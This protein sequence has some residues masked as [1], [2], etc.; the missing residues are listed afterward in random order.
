MFDIIV[1]LKYGKGQRKWY[2]KVKLN[3]Y[4]PHAKFDVYHIHGV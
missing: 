2:V 3:V 1:T 4:Y